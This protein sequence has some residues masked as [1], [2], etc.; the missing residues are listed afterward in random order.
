MWSRY[1]ESVHQHNDMILMSQEFPT[2]HDH[3]LEENCFNDKVGYPTTSKKHNCHWTKIEETFTVLD[4]GYLSS[5]RKI[6]SNFW[7]IMWHGGLWNALSHWNGFW[8]ASVNE[9]TCKNQTLYSISFF[10]NFMRCLL[11]QSFTPHMIF[12]IHFNWCF[13]DPWL[14]FK[15]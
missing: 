12:N 10:G 13:G 14:F 2:Q 7:C 9:E 15:R 8:C 1:N 5:L 11:N 4:F 6:D 3:V